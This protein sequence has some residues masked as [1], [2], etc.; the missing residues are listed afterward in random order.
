[1]RMALVVVEPQ[2]VATMRR[3]SS[4]IGFNYGGFGGR[5]S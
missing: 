2:S 5:K 1:M 4:G 3:M